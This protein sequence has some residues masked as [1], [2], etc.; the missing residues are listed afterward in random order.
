MRINKLAVA[1]WAAFEEE[2]NR[3]VVVFALAGRS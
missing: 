3:T 1:D 2:F